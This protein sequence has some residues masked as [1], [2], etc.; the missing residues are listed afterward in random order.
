L[1]RHCRT[2][3]A[4]T[5]REFTENIIIELDEGAPLIVQLEL[6]SFRLL[7]KTLKDQHI[8]TELS[9]FSISVKCGFLLWKKNINWMYLRTD[10]PTKYMCM[11]L[12]SSYK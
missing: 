1:L 12:R 7:C 5:S 11:Y 4:R 6:F 10:S 2:R 3:T 9:V 8:E